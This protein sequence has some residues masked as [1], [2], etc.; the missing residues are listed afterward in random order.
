MGNVVVPIPVEG[1]VLKKI[2]IKNIR[3]KDKLEIVCYMSRVKIK[4]RNIGNIERSR[5]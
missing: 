3:Q 1:T 2:V 4:Q 5:F